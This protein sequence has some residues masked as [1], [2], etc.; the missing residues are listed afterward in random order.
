LEVFAVWL[1]SQQAGFAQSGI[2]MT[3]GGDGSD[4]A[5]LAAVDGG[6]GAAF[7]AFYR[8]Y[9]PRVVGV[10][11]RETGDREIA[12]DLAA[13]VFA[14]VL[15][16]AGRFRARRN[17]S[18]WPWLQGIARNKLRESWRRGRVEDRA[19]RKLGL[20][21]EALDDNDLARVEDLAS[22]A[23]VMALMQELPDRQR[24]AVRARVIEERSYRDIACELR[25]S[26]MVVR[27]DVSRGLSSMRQRLKG[28]DR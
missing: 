27:Q 22:G 9:L 11:L 26:E 24:A 1:L 8:R 13:E 25:C 14:A 23:G 12:A 5:L 21:P 16:S 10:L 28:R 6:D 15:L 20:E 7:A 3:L 18:A 4:D 19:R 2:E 17:A